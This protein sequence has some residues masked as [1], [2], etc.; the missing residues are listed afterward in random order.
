MPDP[1]PIRVG[2]VPVTCL[3]GDD[4]DKYYYIHPNEGSDEEG[5]PESFGDRRFAESYHPKG[6]DGNDEGG[7]GAACFAQCLEGTLNG[8]VSPAI[9]MSYLYPSNYHSGPNALK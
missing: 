8:A 9:H 6:V 2:L 7:H 5:Y 1:A 4:D 3:S